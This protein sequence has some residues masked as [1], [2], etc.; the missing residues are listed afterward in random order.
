M[1]S[2]GHS[3]SK[4][5]AE[6]L[7]RL[8]LLLEQPEVQLR[9]LH[10]CSQAKK[11]QTWSLI[12]APHTNFLVY[13]LQVCVIFLLLSATAIN[14]YI[15]FAMLKFTT[16]PMYNVSH[17]GS[18]SRLSRQTTECVLLY[19]SIFVLLQFLKPIPSLTPLSLLIW[20]G[21]R[22]H[23]GSSSSLGQVLCLSKPFQFEVTRLLPSP[24]WS[25]HESIQITE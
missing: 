25:H 19:Y 4:R 17:K 18:I 12:S 16:S 13:S 7:W 1:F 14:Y 23:S 2:W 20:N 6:H 21:C 22:Q 5:Q 24:M 15:K 9:A 8:I 3:C 10:Q 11:D